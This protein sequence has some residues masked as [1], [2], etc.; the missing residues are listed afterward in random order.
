MSVLKSSQLA[1]TGF[2]LVSWQVVVLAKMVLPS[3]NG[4]DNHAGFGIVNELAKYYLFIKLQA[5]RRNFWCRDG[6]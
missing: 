4:M 3:L 6:P 2:K 1:S 5:D